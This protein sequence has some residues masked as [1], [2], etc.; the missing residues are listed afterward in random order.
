MKKEEENNRPETLKRNFE[1]LFKENY[2]PLYYYALSLI[3][4]SEICKDLVSDTFHFVWENIA[5]LRMETAKTYLHTHLH[6]L[7]I[8]HLRRSGMML[9]K[10]ESYLAMFREWNENDWEESEERICSIM[11]LIEQMPP[12]TRTVMEQCYL[13]KKKYSEVALLTGL[14]ESGVRK[15]VM[16]G[17]DTIRQ[18]FSVK[19]KKRQ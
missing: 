12:L 15:H 4:D 13:H 17:L 14:S 18:F 9:N 1:Q 2:S 5:T 19:Y 6:R 7:C 16:K 3:P 10:A 11:R 8:D